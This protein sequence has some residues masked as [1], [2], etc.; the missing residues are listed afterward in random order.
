M[1]VSS[2]SREDRARIKARKDESKNFIVPQLFRKYV[3][4]IPAQQQLRSTE[5]LRY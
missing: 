4:G 5:F 2:L 1:P 3:K